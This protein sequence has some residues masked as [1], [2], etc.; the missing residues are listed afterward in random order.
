MQGKSEFRYGL[1]D[2][3]VKSA[4]ALARGEIR[5]V[6]SP[7]A[8]R[9]VRASEQRV[10]A[11]VKTDQTVY[12]VNTGFGPLCNTRISSAQTLKL[13]YNILRSHSVGVGK[14]VEEEI[15]K[16]IL[17]LKTHAL[18]RG[19]SGIS[20]ATLER[21]I[22]MIDT[23]LVPVIPAQ[24]SVGASGDLAPLAH[25]FLPL[26]GLGQVRY[27]GRVTDGGQILKKFNK[28]PLQL[29]PKEGL[30]L[31]NG[32]QFMLAYGLVG[33]D[34][35]KN[36]LDNADIIGAMT[37]ESLLGST[38]PFRKELHRLRP[39][40]GNLYVADKVTK[41]LKGSGMVASHAHCSRVQDPYS[42]RCIPQVHGASWSAWL[43]LKDSLRIELNSVTDNPVIFSDRRAVSGGNFH[44]QPL[45]LPLDYASLAASEVGNI[46]DR[47]SYLLLAGGYEGLPR[48]LMK[49]TGINSGFMI[50]QYTSAALVSENKSLCFPASA[51]SIPTSLGQED[52]VSMG[53]ISA[54][55]FNTVLANLENILAVELLTSAQAFDFRRPMQ[56]SR[57]LEKCHDTIRRYIE[58]ADE[59]RIF[60]EDLQKA[61]RIIT[62]NELPEITRQVAREEKI[63]LF[64]KKFRK[65]EEY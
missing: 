9:A 61:R 5:G 12:G 15:S 29:G 23:H 62:R 45:A 47:R 16:L 10:S 31:I 18:A 34:R 44:G 56:S 51:D 63:N 48:L 49:D 27:R 64:P 46:S 21:I 7:E 33:L 37:L 57:I 8:A 14:A 3:T 26:I 39:F 53:P 52:H 42:L 24:G 22:W 36:L 32:T 13:Q 2:M 11:M 6:L 40:P 55:K 4:L 30:A 28:K 35:F 1:D 38:A 19:Y 17:V 58:H 59:D 25:A 60:G 41:L 54:R 50:P 43:H 65:F 20:L